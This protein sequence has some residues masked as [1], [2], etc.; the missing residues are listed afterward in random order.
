MDIG[1]AS[2]RIFVSKMLIIHQESNTILTQ[3]PCQ[4]MALGEIGTKHSK[5]HSAEH[6]MPYWPHPRARTP[7]TGRCGPPV[8]VRGSARVF[9]VCMSWTSVGVPEKCW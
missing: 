2:H 5:C 6:T 9:L 8:Y 4:N 7:D 1:G 3:M